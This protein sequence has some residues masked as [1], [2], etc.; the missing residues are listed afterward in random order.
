MKTVADQIAAFEKKRVTSAS[1]MDTLMQKTAVEG[2][3]FDEMESAEYDGLLAELEAIDTHLSRLKRLASSA[4]S[5]AQVA[6]D[7]SSVI[8]PD[9]A[10]SVRPN[11]EKGIAF[12]RYVKA[13]AMC[14]GN[15]PGA[16]AMAQN[17][18]VWKETTPQVIEVL[19]AAVSAGDTVTPGWASQLVYNQNMAGE[20]IEFMRPAT[21][22]GRLPGLTRVPFNV[23]MGGVNQG[24]SA[25]WVGQGK[26]VPASKLGTT[27]VLLG[28]AKAAGLVVLT[29]ELV[30]S[31]DP[32]AELLVRNDLTK[33]IA[34]FLDAQF[35]NP[36]FAPVANVSPG[37]ITNGVTP[38]V[39]TGMTA[40]A[41]RADVE[42]MFDVFIGA[43][44]NVQTA[45]WI[46]SPI[47]A[48]RMSMLMN[49][50]G[51]PEFPSLNLNGGLFMGLPVVVSQAANFGGGL[52]VGDNDM[53]ILVNTSDVLLADDDGVAIDASREASIEMLDNP[54]NNATPGLGT[55]MVSM[56]Q[57][58]SVAIKAVRFIN[59]KKRRATAA[60]FMLDSQPNAAPVNTV[61]AARSVANLATL[62]FTGANAVT[63]ADSD[64]LSLTTTLTGNKGTVGVTTGTG[65]AV[66]GNGTAVVTITG[67]VAQINASLAG[68]TYTAN[69]VGAGSLTVATNDGTTTDTDVIA[70]TVT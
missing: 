44:M 20:F 22:L 29:E 1:R 59:W 69:T 4:G 25:Y 10:V 45:T 37:S 5:S 43:N 67:T 32:A 9:G 47:R 16:L 41:V 48:L 3:G 55:N 12:T 2:R 50:A 30:R 33:A 39:P 62:T 14:H 13:L 60:V 46:M 61:S 31:S 38:I 8:V 64:T 35:I 68:L 70:I 36:N 63:I 28:M 11:V 51:E 27:E 40:A 57:A 52:D 34:Q 23:R 66:T 17:N 54:T 56:F 18:P 15:L 53:L 7:G 19:K 65:A 42:T 24:S 26:P 21:I 49:A 58:N 6:N